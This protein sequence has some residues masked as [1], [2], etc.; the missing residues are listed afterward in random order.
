[1]DLARQTTPSDQLGKT[2][3]RLALFQ[4]HLEPS[5]RSQPSS[6]TTPAV[7]KPATMS[8]DPLT[9]H[10]LN[11]L[12]GTPAA[13]LP[14]TL[15]L[16]SAPSTSQTPVVYNAVTNSDGRVANWTPANGSTSTVPAFLSSLPA[17]DS[18]TSWAISFKVGPWY[19]SQGV[20]CFWP[21][22]EVKFNVKGRGKEGQEGWRQ[23]R[24]SVV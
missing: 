7:A 23:D 17:P 13:N 10:V 15:T 5:S 3:D 8:R 4:Q 14:V 1:M 18:K 16:L 12:T 24:K 11:T 21:E 9:C 6:S 19:E 22:V 20:E 2:A